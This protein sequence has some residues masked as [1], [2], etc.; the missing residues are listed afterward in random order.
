MGRN[1]AILLVA[2]GSRERRANEELREMG[3]RLE[4]NLPKGTR[5]HPCYLEIESPSIPDAFADAVREGALSIVVYPFFLSSGR[6][7]LKDIPDILKEC[8][9]EYPETTVTLSPP[10][11]PDPSLDRVVLERLSALLENS[12]P[13]PETT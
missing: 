4:E 10:L 13:E 1:T 8:R 12:G 6:H 5:V 2:H 9:K 3:T 11:G 7:A